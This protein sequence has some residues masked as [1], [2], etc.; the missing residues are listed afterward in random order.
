MI[1]RKAQ[2]FLAR[3]IEGGLLRRA[4]G[5]R[6]A[7]LAVRLCRLDKVMGV[8]LYAGVDAD[9]DV[10]HPAALAAQLVEHVYLGERIDD[11][12]PHAVLDG[13]DELGTLLIVAVH[14]DAPGG[15]PRPQR[16][17]Q[18][19]AGDD[20]DAYLLLRRDL[21]DGKAGKGLGCVQ[22]QPVAV[23]FAF[24]GVAVNA[25]HVADVLFVHHIQRRAEFFRQLQRIRSPDL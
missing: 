8:R 15:E 4:V 17:V 14:I 1:A 6:K 25:A 3:G 24:D 23:V 12:G 13:V 22:H 9:E 20:V 16:R 21:I 10:L 7:E 19:A 18:L 5:D 2:I 11:N